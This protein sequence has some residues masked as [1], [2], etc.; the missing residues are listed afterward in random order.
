MILR[1]VFF[2]V[3][4]C[5]SIGFCLIWSL[6]VVVLHI[7]SFCVALG[8]PSFVFLCA[9]GCSFDGGLQEHFP[10]KNS[11]KHISSEGNHLL[12]ATPVAGERATGSP[13]D[14]VNFRS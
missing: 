14:D 9:V 4:L 7:V 1:D 13:G 8:L 3:F 11:V 10:N 2:C 12:R 6:V 5:V